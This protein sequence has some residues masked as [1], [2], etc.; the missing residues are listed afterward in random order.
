MATDQGPVVQ[1]ALLRN[2]L[3]RLRKDSGLTQEQVAERLD[4]SPSKLIR[5]EGGRSS[6]TKVDLDALLT[7]YG[8]SSESHHERLQALNRGARERAWWSPYRDEVNATY[9]EYVGYEAG[10]AFIRQFHGGSLPGLLQTPEYAEVL[11]ANSVDAIRVASVVKLRLQRQ[12][13]LGRRSSPP[14]QY[15]VIDEAVIR[16]H[17]GISQ[18]PAIMPNQLRFIA[19]RAEREEALTVRVIPFK[20]GAHTGLTGPF[21]LLEFAGTMSDLLYLDNGRDPAL[22]MGSDPRIAQAADDFEDLLENALSATESVELI[23]QVAED[24]S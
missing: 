9:L 1:S 3:I 16:R 17:V 23:G 4:W 11:T 10:A 20:A 8:I 19:D 2:E 21:T 7:T 6:I 24:M 22:I 18:D 12:A 5:V 13:E 14:R 15:Y